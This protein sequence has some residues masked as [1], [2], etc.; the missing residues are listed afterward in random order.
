MAFGFPVPEYEVP[1][2]DQAHVQE[3]MASNHCAVLAVPR[4]TCPRIVIVMWWLIE[5]WSH[6]AKTN[7]RI[8]EKA[9]LLRVPLGGS[10]IVMCGSSK[11]AAYIVT[12][13]IIC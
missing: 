7:P 12:A 8:P 11:S 5:Q 3:G 1:M 13:A 10:R 2:A 6:T 4:R 9:L